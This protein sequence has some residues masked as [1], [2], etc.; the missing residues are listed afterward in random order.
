MKLNLSVP[1]FHSEES[2]RPNVSQTSL[3]KGTKENSDS[4]V[5]QK[6]PANF[7]FKVAK[8]FELKQKKNKQKK[9]PQWALY[10]LQSNV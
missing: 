7:P 1:G 6:N 10:K 5:I 2:N 8:W 3:F 9:T 4:K